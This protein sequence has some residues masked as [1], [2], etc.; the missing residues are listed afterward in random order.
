MKS[1]ANI[2]GHPLHPILVSFPVA[3]F[4]GALFFDVLNA[5]G[6]HNFYNTALYLEMAGVCLAV[7][8][9]VPGLIDFIYTVPPKSTGKTRAAKHGLTN[10]GMLLCFGAALFYRLNTALPNPIVLIG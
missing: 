4:T 9:A 8:A 7:V 3:F 6:K 1:T 5:I 10:V 2:K